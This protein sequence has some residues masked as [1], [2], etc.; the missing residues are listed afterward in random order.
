[1]LLS[2]TEPCAHLRVPHTVGAQR[3][4]RHEWWE[5]AGRASSVGTCNSGNF[6]FL[7]VPPLSSQVSQLLS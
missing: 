1:M 6:H 3:H 2:S 4:L 5:E 7:Q